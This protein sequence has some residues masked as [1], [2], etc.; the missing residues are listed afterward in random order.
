MP[1]ASSDFGGKQAVLRPDIPLVDLQQTG[2]AAD[3]LEGAMMLARY[4]LDSV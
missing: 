3:S 4:S 1:F 2:L